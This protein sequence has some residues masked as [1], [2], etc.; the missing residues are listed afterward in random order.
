MN[1]PQTPYDSGTP[2]RHPAVAI[3]FDPSGHHPKVR[4]W[5]LA[6][7]VVAASLYAIGLVVMIGGI[8][9]HDEDLS[10][11]FFLG[12]WAVL[13][14]GA[15]LLNAKL[16]LGM[17]WLH[18]AW[19]W[20][21]PEQRFDKTGKRFGPDNVFML[22]IPYYNFYYMFVINFALCDAMQRMQASAR[23]NET[24]TRDMVMWACVLEIIPFANFFVSPFLWAKYMRRVDTM[25]EEIAR[26]ATPMMAHA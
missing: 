8:A 11:F 1:Y 2:F 24:V 15:L 12:G 9:I 22:L 3:T 19:K 5:F 23:T 10:P 14:F 20:V 21:P 25:H 16:I 6:G 4:P 13:M 26:S 7:A 18:Q 17:Y